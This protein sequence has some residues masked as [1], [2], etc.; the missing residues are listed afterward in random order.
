MHSR[1]QHT[2]NQVHD[3]GRDHDMHR[4]VL[5]NLTVFRISAYVQTP[6]SSVALHEQIVDLQSGN[7]TKSLFVVRQ[8][9]WTIVSYAFTAPHSATH[10]SVFES[11]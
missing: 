8:T 2:W 7:P 10:A 11:L 4:P 9:I 5:L 1:F 3:I 6:F